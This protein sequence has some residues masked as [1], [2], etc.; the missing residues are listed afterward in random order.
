[1]LTAAQIAGARS[2]HQCSNAWDRI[3]TSSVKLQA[4]GLMSCATCS[5]LCLQRLSLNLG[6]SNPSVP[7]KSLNA[8]LEV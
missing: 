5:R 3:C 4:D 6:Q 7:C 1:M 2:T 8:L